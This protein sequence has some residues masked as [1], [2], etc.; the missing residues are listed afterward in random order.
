MH[1]KTVGV[2][3]VWLKFAISQKNTKTC[4]S[5]NI[6]SLEKIIDWP[7]TVQGRI[8]VRVEGVSYW[9]R[10][11]LISAGMLS[12]VTW[13]TTQ[14]SKQCEKSWGSEQVWKYECRGA[15]D[16]SALP[17]RER[18]AAPT[19]GAKIPWGGCKCIYLSKKIDTAWKSNGTCVYG[20][21][22]GLTSQT[23][24]GNTMWRRNITN[25]PLIH[26][27][28]KG[29]ACVHVPKGR[30]IR[31]WSSVSYFRVGSHPLTTQKWCTMKI[32]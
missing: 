30:R 17:A 11:A 28:N 2:I 9:S 19:G 12:G 15:A 4:P 13:V 6:P 3:L 14:P 1:K 29:N 31:K 8:T 26:K 25:R 10:H 23:D 27:W 32:F 16:V 18:A 24:S 7:S 22:T 21:V 5:V 20:T